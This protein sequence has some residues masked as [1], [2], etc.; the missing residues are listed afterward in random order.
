LTENIV[1]LGA[2]FRP[3]AVFWPPTTSSRATNPRQVPFLP[4]A[5]I[6]CGGRGQQSFSCTELHSSR[7]HTVH[8]AAHFALTM[9]S[10][11]ADR[12][13]SST[14]GGAQPLHL[15]SFSRMEIADFDSRGRYPTTPS[16]QDTRTGPSVPNSWYPG[17]STAL[18]LPNGLQGQQDQS[19][20]EGNI[21]SSNYPANISLSSQLILL[22]N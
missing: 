1:R 3:P 19:Y 18:N 8:T 13:R 10:T 15:G 4:S 12:V 11:T 16:P 5:I 14:G 6:S 21:N 20:R 2:S 7:R 22:F 17:D 9:A